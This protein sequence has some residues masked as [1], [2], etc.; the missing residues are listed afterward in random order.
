[1]SSFTDETTAYISS[2]SIEDRKAA[3]Q[4][5]T[6]NYLGKRM[7]SYL[8][9]FVEEKT[10]NGEIIKVL[11][12]AV[13]TGELLRAFDEVFPNVKKKFY[14]FDIEQ[15]M[16][17]TAKKNVKGIDVCIKSIFEPVG[18]HENMADVIIGNPP[19]FEIKKDFPELANIDFDTKNEKG[20]L[21]IYSLFFEYA[22]RLLKHDGV[23]VYLVPPSMNNGAYFKELRKFILNNFTIELIEIIRDNKHFDDALTSVQIVVLKK[24]PEPTV[25]VYGDIKNSKFIVDFNNITSHKSDI[26]LP[27]IFT[28]NAKHIKKYWSG[29][30]SLADAG[31]KVKTGNTIWN[32]HKHNFVTVKTH[33]SI[34]APLLYSK[35]IVNNNLVLDAKLDDRRWLPITDKVTQEP[36]IIVNRIVGSLSNPQLKYTLVDLPEYYTENHVNV[37]TVP[38]VSRN[39]A[40]KMLKELIKEFNNSETWL[41]DYLQCITGNTQVSATELLY[42]IP[43]V[44]KK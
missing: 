1:M 9:T 44:T 37:I 8:K 39:E 21:N 5:M 24:K 36:S 20:R 32:E 42:L 13:G 29:R 40:L 27:T 15:G 3:G 2:L 7:S 11:D 38:N 10:Q 6:P 19:Y 17:D 41:K 33:T 18:I 26:V 23:M 22:A 14:G 25:P 34:H 28:D 16:I 43:F 35:D 30:Q 12:P 4:Y 31:F